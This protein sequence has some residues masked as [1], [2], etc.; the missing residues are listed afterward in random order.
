MLGASLSCFD[1]G[2]IGRRK[3]DIGSK[4]FQADFQRGKQFFKVCS[5]KFTLLD[6]CE[7][8]QIAKSP[9]RG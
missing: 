3:A 5:T 1:F 9:V 6:V 7:F 2:E 8:F 4:L